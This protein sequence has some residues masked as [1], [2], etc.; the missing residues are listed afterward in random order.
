MITSRTAAAITLADKLK[1]DGAPH[2]APPAC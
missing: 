2:D 1:L